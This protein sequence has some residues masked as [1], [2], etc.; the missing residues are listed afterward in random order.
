MRITNILKF[1]SFYGIR[2]LKLGVARAV[3]IAQRDFGFAP[4][5]VMKICTVRDLLR[6]HGTIKPVPSRP[7]LIELIEDGR[8]EGYYNEDLHCYVV[9]EDSFLAWLRRTAPP[10]PSPIAQPI[11]A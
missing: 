8:I 9:F 2:I 5:S 11:A 6:Q 10:A 3:T 4:R 7:K 1:Y